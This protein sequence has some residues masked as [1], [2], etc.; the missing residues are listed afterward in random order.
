MREIHPQINIK[1]LTVTRGDKDIDLENHKEY[2]Y[3]THEANKNY[4]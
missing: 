2:L 1:Y 4:I 3:A